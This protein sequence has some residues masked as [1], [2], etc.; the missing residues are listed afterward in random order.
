MLSPELKEPHIETNEDGLQFRHHGY[1]ELK[2]VKC[3]NNF[4]AAIDARVTTCGDR[5]CGK[6]AA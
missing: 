3:G 2:C 1:A 4:I 5:N 6:T